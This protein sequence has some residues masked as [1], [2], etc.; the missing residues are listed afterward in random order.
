MGAHLT[1]VR[2]G[3]GLWALMTPVL[4]LLYMTVRVSPDQALFDY[5]AW[6]HIQGAIYYVDVAEQN[7]P[8]KMFL[9]ELGIRLF[10]VHFWTFRLT[11]FLLLQAVTIAGALYLRGQGFRHAPWIFLL[12]YPPLYVSSGYWM[13]GQRDIVAA[14]VLVISM[15]WATSGNRERPLW[16]LAGAGAL[17][18]FAVL[19]RPTYLPFFFGLLTLFWLRFSGEKPSLHTALG[20]SAVLCIGFAAPITLLVWIGW[21]YGA[22]DDWYQQAILFNLQAYSVPQSRWTL[23]SPALDHLA[24]SWHWITVC[25]L[26]GLLAWIRQG[27]WRSLVLI[28]GLIATVLVSYFAQNKGFGYHLGGLLP[29]FVLLIAG[30]IDHAARSWATSRT[31]LRF[32]TLAIITTLCL[33]GTVKKL[34]HLR[35]NL[36]IILAGNL[37]PIAP[38]GDGLPFDVLSQ[39]VEEVSKATSPDTR[40]MQWGR[41]FEFGYL[42]QRQSSTRF[43]STPAISL[44]RQSH[45]IGKDWLAEFEASLAAHPPAFLLIDRTALETAGGGAEG[46]RPIAALAVRYRPVLEHE[47]AILFRA[48]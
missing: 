15:H 34:T 47:A 2:L 10:G 35:P 7:F 9:H 13:A 45:S 12:L 31:L 37:A 24:Q 3:M 18:A 8:G 33:A 30:L 32:G 6:S 4:G 48:P 1:P 20:R 5:I 38:P 44:L 19:V 11:D 43:V 28:L 29:A 27:L 36:N 40:I 46:Y 14:G 42:A 21:R 41:N 22:L 25:A 16:F 17:C 39:M 26:L 23:W